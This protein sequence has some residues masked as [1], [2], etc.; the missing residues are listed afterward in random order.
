MCVC[1][2][3]CM[4]PVCIFVCVLGLE[5]IIIIVSQMLCDFKVLLMPIESNRHL[6]L[7]KAS[8]NK[9]TAEYADNMSKH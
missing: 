1:V 3:V 7:A 9:K 8:N 6:L 5:H 2:S 4:R